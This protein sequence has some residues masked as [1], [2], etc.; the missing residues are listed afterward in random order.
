ME[1]AIAVVETEG[2]LNRPEDAGDC[3]AGFVEV[4][5][6]PFLDW[7]SVWE[8]DA[9]GDR[10]TSS[11]AESAS[12]GCIVSSPP[13]PEQVAAGCAGSARPDGGSVGAARGGLAV[14]PAAWRWPEAPV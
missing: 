5:V 7:A 14:A 10:N 1:F 8:S 3:V 11:S 2:G 13:G 6:V 12:V 9:S 4:S